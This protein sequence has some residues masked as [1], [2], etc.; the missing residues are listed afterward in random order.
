MKNF[1]KDVYAYIDKLTFH[2]VISINISAYIRLCVKYCVADIVRLHRET[3]FKIGKTYI[4]YTDIIV[5]F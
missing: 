2:A 5:C 4:L 1:I 3:F